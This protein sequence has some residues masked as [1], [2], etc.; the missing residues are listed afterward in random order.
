MPGHD[1]V[2]LAAIEREKQALKDAFTYRSLRHDT[3]LVLGDLDRAMFAEACDAGRPLYPIASDFVLDCYYDKGVLEPLVKAYSGQPYRIASRFDRLLQHLEAAERV[4]L[5]ERFWTSIARLTRAE[6]FYQR[7]RRNHGDLAGA[8]EFKTYALEAYARG[9]EWLTRLGRLDAARRLTDESEALR[10][11]HLPTR[12][13]PSDLRRIDE[14]VFWDLIAT[15][16]SHAS[17]T[18]EQLA[19]LGE[20]L[21][22]FDAADVKR[23][24]SLYVKFMRRLYHWNVWALAYAA[25]GGCSDGAFEAFRT[26]LILQGDPALVSLAVTDPSRA[27]ERVPAEPD[28]PDGHCLPMLEESYLLRKGSWLE[29]PPIDLDEPKGR[30]WAE[31]TFAATYPELVRRYASL[32]EL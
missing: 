17:A 7:P 8:E 2:D 21:R 1:R 26:W 12:P 11:E 22:A 9:I 31:E 18:L 14:P 20:S 25:R 13:P 29:L 24:G 27:A 28:L 30:E 3:D 19:A 5:V 23:F 15:A 10:D 16:R 6:F 32:R 4:D